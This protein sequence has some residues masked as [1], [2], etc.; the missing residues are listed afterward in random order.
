MCHTDEAV[1]HAA[2]NSQDL[3]K[4]AECYE[5]SEATSSLDSVCNG[6]PSLSSRTQNQAR[7]LTETSQNVSTL[8]DA[9]SPGQDGSSGKPFRYAQLQK[10]LCDWR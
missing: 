8:E 7:L 6:L 10:C 1:S 2:S 4:Q 3:D 9:M 5:L